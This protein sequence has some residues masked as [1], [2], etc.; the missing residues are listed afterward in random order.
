M[1]V[2]VHSLI[3]CTAICAAAVACGRPSPVAPDAAASATPPGQQAS[4]PTSVPRNSYLGTSTQGTAVPL[5]AGSLSIVNAKGDGISG[6]YTGTVQFIGGGIETASLIVTIS[7]GS[8]AFAGASGNLAMTGGGSLADEG[9]F[10]LSG[11]GSITIAGQKSAFVTI[12]LRGVSVLGCDISAGQATIT[13]NAQGVMS[14]AGTVSA[15]LHHE[16]GTPGCTP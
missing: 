9:D 16:V 3:V 12:G 4:G 10:L 5:V 15:T 6:T 1:N 11:S 8:G 14:R 7:S 13:A 2:R